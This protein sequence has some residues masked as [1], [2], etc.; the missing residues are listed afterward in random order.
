MT[1]WEDIWSKLTNLKQKV[2]NESKRVLKKQVPTIESV[3]AEIRDNL[4]M[5]YNQFVKEVIN[6]QSALD[7]G[8]LNLVKKLF[9]HLRDRVVRSY[10]VL[11]VPYKIPTSCIELIKAD[12]LDEDLNFDEEELETRNSIDQLLLNMATTN[13]EFFNFAAKILPN[14]FDGSPQRLQSFIDALNLLKVNSVGH[15]ENVRIFVRTKLIGKARELVSD[16]DSLEDIITKL[17]TGIRTDSSQMVSSKLLA[18]KKSNKD[19]TKY[20]TEV[21][22]L[23][24]SLKRAYIAEGVPGQVA[25]KYATQCTVNSLKLNTNSEKIKIIMEAATMATFSVRKY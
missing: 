16:N 13:F 18:L 2:I 3:R 14:E 1:S 7:D 5:H 24:T 19:T 22:E 10:Q 4:L 9:S 15:E 20:A 25:E 6:I 12:V 21:E 11:K 8:Q 23:S 17:T